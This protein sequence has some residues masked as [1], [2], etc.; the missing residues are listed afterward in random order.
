MKLGINLYPH[1][2]EAINKL[3]SGC[4]LCGGV[5]TGK[6]ITAYA[7]YLKNYRDLKL[8]VITTASKR[9]SFEW[10]DDYFAI[11]VSKFKYPPIVDSWN[12]IE[13]Y[14]SIENA[15][16]IF[17]EQKA[18]GN[19]TWGKTFVKI[20][21]KNKWIILTATPGDNWLDY[22]NFFIAN[23]AYK[24]KTD[25]YRQH[26]VLSPFCNFPKVEKYI[27]TDRLIFAKDKLLVYMYMNKPADREIK[28][29]KVNYDMELYFNTTKFRKN[30]DGEPIKNASEFFYRLREIVNSDKSRV[31]TIKQILTEHPKAI[32][33]YN[34]NYELDLLLEAFKDS[35]Y[36]VAQYNGFIHEEIPKSDK[37]VFLVQYMA[38]AEG[39]NCIETDTIIFYSQSYSYKQTEQAMGRIDRLNTPFKKL[40]YYFLVSSARVDVLIRRCLENKK[41]FNLKNIKSEFK[42]E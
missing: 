5:G 35:E 15:F 16:F 13:K 8:Y 7:F 2:I 24:N 22:M 31:E 18:I 38:G 23:G 37:W 9:D 10:D 25:F 6:S 30:A 36:T 33:F 32:I 12:N 29:L 39:W 26:V 17:D 21:K 3:R 42:E 27:N 14:T 41:D 1:Q 20:A 34:F 11:G 4:C 40:Y 19:G 28:K